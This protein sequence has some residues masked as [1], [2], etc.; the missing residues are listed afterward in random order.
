ML[1]S[2]KGKPVISAV[3][4]CSGEDN[5]DKLNDI[6]LEQAEIIVRTID[7]QF[8]TVNAWHT[9][10]PMLA[11]G[12]LDPT[13]YP[14]PRDQEEAHVHAVRSLTERY[15]ISPGDLY[16]EA[17]S[18]SDV[19]NDVAFRIDAGLIVMGTVARTGIRGALIGNTAERVLEATSCDIMV[20]KLPLET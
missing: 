7:S 1:D 9:M 14:T 5:H 12:T 18:P 16:V 3:D 17:G 4:V 20:V 15:D 8:V 10:T 11:V 13:P 2:I 19:I 6:V